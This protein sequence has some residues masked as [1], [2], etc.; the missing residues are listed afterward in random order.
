LR[1]ASDLGAGGDNRDLVDEALHQNRRVGVRRGNRVID[2]PVAHQRRRTD[3]AGPHVAGLE[4]A[5]WQGTECRQIGQK[6]L[7]DRLRFPTRLSSR[8]ARH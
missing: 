6:P 2:V 4:G 5:A 1:V 8:R 3:P 7:A